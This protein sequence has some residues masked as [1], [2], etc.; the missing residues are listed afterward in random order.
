MDQRRGLATFQPSKH[1]L[2][3][4]RKIKF[5][6]NIVTTNA[7]TTEPS[8]RS[9]VQGFSWIDR[10]TPRDTEYSYRVM[11]LVGKPGELQAMEPLSSA[12]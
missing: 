8:T 4:F 3:T 10:P 5:N 2:A 7:M 11:P 1:H 9:P 12:A 6:E